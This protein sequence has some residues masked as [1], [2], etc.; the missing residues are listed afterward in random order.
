M[1]MD[2]YNGCLWGKNI[3]SLAGLIFVKPLFFE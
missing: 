1:K 3:F 2:K